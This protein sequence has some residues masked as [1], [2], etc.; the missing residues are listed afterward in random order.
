MHSAYAK[1]HDLVILDRLPVPEIVAPSQGMFRLM[2]LDTETTGVDT[3]K[4]EL[5]ELAYVIVEFNS[6]GELLNVV[7]TY[8]EL[9]QPDLSILNSNVHGITD[10]DCLGKTIDWAVVAKDVESCHL[11]T[12]H[13]AGFD[14]KIVERYCEAFIPV[15]WCCSYKDV[16]YSKLGINT[17]KLDYLAYKAGFHF[18]AHRALLDV[19]ATLEVIKR[20]NIFKEML[21]A[22]QSISY[23]V[24]AANAP[25]SAKDALKEDGYNALYVKGKFVSWYKIVSSDELDA[26]LEW[27]TTKAGCRNTPFLA[28]SSKERY[29]V[30]EDM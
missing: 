15:A 1:E 22:A 17:Q 11:I 21:L 3:S 9:R 10:E 14:R 25:F 28:V 8:E 2:V 6:A 24:H 26:T 5:I 30:R 27:L 18:N 12:A 29:S 4:D 23:V 20:L 16:D 13:N 19:L 7:K